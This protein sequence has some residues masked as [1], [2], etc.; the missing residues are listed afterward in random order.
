MPRSLPASTN[1]S[2]RKPSI[3]SSTPRAFVPGV[4]AALQ[5]PRK[6]RYYLA[7][8]GDRVVG[9][10]MITFEWSDWRN[11]TFWWLQSVYVDPA[12]RQRGVFRLLFRTIEQEAR[13]DAGVCGIRLYVEGD[14]LRA[15]QTYAALGMDMRAY[16][17]CEIDFVLH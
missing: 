7:V 1:N 4:T 5:D 6:G 15:Q 12:Y 3:S 11:G 17:F 13:A 16:R 10:T 8:E 14:N 9:Q 2:P